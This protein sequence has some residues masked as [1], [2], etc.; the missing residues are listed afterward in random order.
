MPESYADRVTK[1]LEGLPESSAMTSAGK[2]VEYYG[3]VHAGTPAFPAWGQD[4]V[5]KTAWRVDLKDRL[6]R[7]MFQNN[8]AFTKLAP[9][10]SH[11]SLLADWANGGNTTSCN[12]FIGYM[13]TSQGIHGFSGFD[14]ENVLKKQGKAHCWVTPGSGEFPQYGDLFET[15]SWN[16]KGHYNQHVGMHL[17]LEGDVWRT[18]EG[19]QGGSIRGADMIARCKRKWNVEHMRGWIDMRLLTSGRAPPP[20]W[21]VGT[22]VVYIGNDTWIYEVTRSGTLTCRAYRPNMVGAPTTPIV[23]EGEISWSAA[24]SA[25]LNWNTEGGYEKISPDRVNSRGWMDQ[26]LTGTTVEGKPLK[27]IKM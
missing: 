17:S 26:R 21:L 15:R 23:D 13:T 24:D 11:T 7:G 12:A 3:E 19:G 1:L 10:Y 25:H 22:W 6:K 27:A 9:P 20:G 5:S 16:P 8:A 18:V 4:G 14:F 2:N